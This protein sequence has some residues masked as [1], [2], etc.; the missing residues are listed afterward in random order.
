M[1]YTVNKPNGTIVATVAD[2]TIDTT[3]DLIL[4]G[5]NYAGYGE[6]LTKTSETTGKFCKQ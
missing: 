4:V 2:G 6:F 5:K 1:A 3:T